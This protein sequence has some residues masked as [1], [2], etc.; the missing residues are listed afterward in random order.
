ME[1]FSENRASH[2]TIEVTEGE[3]V[4]Y[5][6]LSLFVTISDEGFCEAR[7]YTWITIENCTAFVTALHRCEQTRRG[8]A[9]LSG[10]SLGEF[11]I[12]IESCDSVGH[13]RLQYQLAQAAYNRGAYQERTVSGVFDLDSGFFAEIVASFAELL[14]DA[15]HH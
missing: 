10:M 15:E 12:V 5:P 7:G 13:F 2:L 11:E 1:L 6:S 14:P 9:A 8:R 3:F 4:R